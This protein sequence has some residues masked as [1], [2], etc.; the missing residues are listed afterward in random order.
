MKVNVAETL[1]RRTYFLL[2]VSEPADTLPLS[3]DK[4]ATPLAASS[5]EAPSIAAPASSATREQDKL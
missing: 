5:A 3:I 2:K 1:W 4:S